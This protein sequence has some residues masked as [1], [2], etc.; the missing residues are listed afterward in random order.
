M[1][2][3]DLFQLHLDIL[4]PGDAFSVPLESEI[5]HCKDETEENF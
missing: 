5:S 3:V 2:T 4:L 1:D